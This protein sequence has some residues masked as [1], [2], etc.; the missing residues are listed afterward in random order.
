MGKIGGSQLVLTEADGPL[1][2]SPIMGEV[3]SRG[4]VFDCAKHSMRHLPLHGG[5]W[6]GA[7][8]LSLPFAERQGAS[9]VPPLAKTKDLAALS[10]SFRFLPRMGGDG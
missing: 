9:R 7:V 4:S 1:P 2:A 5:G 8:S 3:K 10:P 6:E